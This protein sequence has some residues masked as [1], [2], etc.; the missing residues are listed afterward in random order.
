MLHSSS[1]I[2]CNDGGN[3]SSHNRSFRRY[4]SSTLRCKPVTRSICMNKIETSIVGLKFVGS[5]ASAIG[6]AIDLLVACWS[7]HTPSKLL[8]QQNTYALHGRFDHFRSIPLIVH[9]FEKPGSAH[10]QSCTLVI[11]RLRI[12]LS[13][14]T[15]N[16]LT[17]SY[18][19]VFRRWGAWYFLLMKNCGTIFIFFIVH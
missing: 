9:W 8:T 14:F 10:R 18:S 19:G 1:R 3:K 7:L 13:L 11:Y 15:K 12:Q 4:L 5:P 17:S 16:L 6:L 2:L